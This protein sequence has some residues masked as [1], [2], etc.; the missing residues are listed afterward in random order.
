[1]DPGLILYIMSYAISYPNC[2]I[3]WEILIQTEI[4][5]ANAEAECVALSQAIRYI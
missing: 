4:T 1:M 5:F 2:L 3:I